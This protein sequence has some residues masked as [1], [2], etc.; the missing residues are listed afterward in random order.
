MVCHESQSH[1]CRFLYGSR[2]SLK[3]YVFSLGQMR[4]A[5]FV[6]CGWK[7]AEHMPLCGLDILFLF[8]ISNT[9]ESAL[10]CSYH[11]VTHWK[12]RADGIYSCTVG[13][14][15]VVWFIAPHTHTQKCYLCVYLYFFPYSFID[16]Y[17][18]QI[19]ASWKLSIK[20]LF[21]CSGGSANQQQ[22]F[23]FYRMLGTDD[24]SLISWGVLSVLRH[25]LSAICSL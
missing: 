21:F 3:Q 13:H 10:F 25:C 7:L 9:A 4:A 16:S 15:A 8:V 5:L 18:L 12:W 23:C 19:F 14:I 24:S 6:L 2:L 17:A 20:W 22:V 1:W 11:C